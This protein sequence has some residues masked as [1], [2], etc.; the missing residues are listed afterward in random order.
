M[1]ASV[2]E[3][4]ERGATCDSSRVRTLSSEGCMDRARCRRVDMC[5]PKTRNIALSRLVA[6]Q[7]I[8]FRLAPVK[9]QL[10]TRTEATSGK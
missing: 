3:S 9:V 7:H 10:A 2:I 8:V 6:P 5:D 1:S 4:P